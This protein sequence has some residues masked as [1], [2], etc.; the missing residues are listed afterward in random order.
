LIGE[1]VPKKATA[2]VKAP[3]HLRPATRDWYERVITNYE[4]ED[5]H[6]HLLRLA[7]E[8][9]DR[10]NEARRAVNKHGLVFTDRLGNCR[11]RPEA[12]MEIE[13]RTS[14]ARLLRELAIDVDPPAESNRPNP[15]R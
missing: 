3:S 7:C 8:A 4:L 14:F 6:L 5:H 1:K 10:A 11:A 12:K 9:L 13:N 2:A 15:L